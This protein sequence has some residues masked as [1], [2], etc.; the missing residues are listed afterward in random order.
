[1]HIA[2]IGAGIIGLNSAYQ[3]LKNGFKVSLIDKESRIANLTSYQNGGQLSYSHALPVNMVASYKNLYLGTVLNHYPQKFD[4]IEIM[5]DTDWLFKFW[6]NKKYSLEKKLISRYLDLALESK[7]LIKQISKDIGFK[8]IKDSG[9]LHLFRNQSNFEKYKNLLEQSDKFDYQIIEAE[10][11]KNYAANIKHQKFKKSCLVKNDQCA[12][13]RDFAL[14][15]FEKIKSHKNSQ[16]YL[17][18]EITKFETEN[19]QIKKIIFPD[20]N[21]LAADHVIL[22]SGALSD[23]L[24]KNLNIDLLIRPVKGYSTNITNNSVKAAIIDNDAKMV[25]SPLGK[26]I[27]AA[28]LY[29]FV[30]FNKKIRNYRKSTFLNSVTDI[31]KLD[32]NLDYQLWQGFRA[33]S[34]DGLPI[35]GRSKKYQNLH[36]NLAH[37]NLGWTLSAVSGKLLIAEILEQDNDYSFLSPERFYL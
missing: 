36:Y 5:K 31:I 29:D 6:Y 22:A 30:G 8:D 10:E 37:A 15:L 28:G 16:I 32:N 35:I 20:G 18:S 13:S 17:N 14:K 24:V 2:I 12:N 21:V 33:I 1:M 7:A 34:Q 26:E 9:S 19:N 3:A 4:F 25:Y 23:K 11:L 27:R